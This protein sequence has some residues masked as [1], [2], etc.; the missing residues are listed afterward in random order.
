MTTSALNIARTQI[1]GC[2]NTSDAI[3]F[4]GHTGSGGVATTEKYGG[5]SWVTTNSLNGVR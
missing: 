3:S 5:S 4:G 2:G 1:S